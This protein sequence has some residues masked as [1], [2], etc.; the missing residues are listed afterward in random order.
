MEDDG[1]RERE[2]KDPRLMSVSLLKPKTILKFCFLHMPELWRL[3]QCI[4]HLNQK[5]R[6]CMTCKWLCVR[7]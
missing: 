4:L 3:K 2:K 5:A 6:K 7:F 1:R